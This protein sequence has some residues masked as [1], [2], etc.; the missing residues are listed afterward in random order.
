M[1][2]RIDYIDIIKGI[3]IWGVVWFHTYH[4]DWLT[5]LL[6]NSIFFF[7]SG[8]FF[9][10]ENFWIFLR[11]KSSTLIVPFLFFYLVS[12]LFY[13]L[14]YFWDFQTLA[15]FDWMVYREIFMVSARTDYISIN[16]VL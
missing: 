11:K 4:P 13:V 15:G 2:G 14:V 1:N 3:T 5:A 6:V 9:K 10:R 8:I 16:I 12:Y 7:L